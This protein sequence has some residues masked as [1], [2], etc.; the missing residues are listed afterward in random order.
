MTPNRR[1]FLN[2]VATYGR[3]LFALICGLFSGRWVLMS[4]GVTDYGLYGLIGGMTVFIVFINNLLGGALARFYAFSIGRVSVVERMEVGL[5]ECRRWFSIAVFIHTVIPLIL[6]VFGYQCGLYAVRNW[7]VIPSSRLEICIWVWRFVCLS[8]FVGMINVPLSAM[9]IA[10][11]YIAE[12]TV[13]SFVQTLANIC[14]AYYMVVHPGEWL[15]GYALFACLVNVIPQFVI[16]VRAIRLFPECRFVLAYCWDWHRLKELVNFAAWQSFGAFTGIAR[17]QCLAILVNRNFGVNVNAAMAVSGTI[18]SH[19]Q[20]LVSALQS[21]L[22]PAI[23]SAFGSGDM[24]LMRRL[25]IRACKFGAM[26]S[27]IFV[28]PLSLELEEVLVLWLKDPPQF[29]GGLCLCMML[30]IVFDKLTLGHMIAVNAS[31]RIAFYQF[32]VGLGLIMAFPLGWLLVNLGYGVYSVGFALTVTTALASLL[33]V[34]LAKARV[35]MLPIAWFRDV[36][37]PVGSISIVTAAVGYLPRYMFIAS[38][39]RVAATTVLVELFMLP[40]F[41]F[42]LLDKYERDFFLS[43]MSSLNEKIKKM[44]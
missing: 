29:A 32:V 3:S 11:Q 12:L 5:E 14:F 10:K 24:G 33:R 17:N 35:G 43:R 7:L 4:L 9:Y 16:C 44:F 39:F 28:V 36:L 38:F 31:G 15:F 30:S 19:S 1:I 6:I 18:N 41:W 22:T 27:L 37:F 2:V 40:L 34:G 13:Y 20:S 42:L 23:T 25:S 21:A 26:C 8:C